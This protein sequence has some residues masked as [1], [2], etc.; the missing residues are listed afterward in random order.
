MVR[1]FAGVAAEL[2]V[3]LDNK[4]VALV[5][6]HRF[7]EA[8]AASAWRSRPTPATPWRSETGPRALLPGVST[9]GWAGRE[10]RWK[11]SSF[12]PVYPRF[13]A[14]MWLGG[15]PSRGQDHSGLQQ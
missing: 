2:A 3:T 7:E 5:Q 10:A 14:P 1:S 4:A 9:A 15:E 11:V 13:S 6:L 12:R 8:I